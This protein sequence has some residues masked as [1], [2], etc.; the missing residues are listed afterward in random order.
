MNSD[1][2]NT[3]MRPL[4]L[5]ILLCYA[6][7]SLGAAESPMWK[8]LTP[9]QQ[10]LLSTGKP[11]VIEEN[12]GENPWPRYVVYRLVNSSAEKAAAVFW[13]CELDTR[14]IPNCLIVRTVARPQPWI[15][16]AEYT[17]KMPMF[18]PNEVYLSRN[19]L[20]TPSSGDYEISW[21]VLHARY[22][23]GSTGNIR[24]EPL[25]LTNQNVGNGEKALM[26]YSNLVIPGGRIACLLRAQARQQVVDS[27]NA[28]ARQVDQE[29]S[30][31]S[32][33]QI[34]ELKKALVGTD[35]AH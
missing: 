25:E 16:E 6:L 32:E 29:S 5:S 1:D 20:T 28:L 34:A 30:Q 13:D 27:V 22:I 23:T 18:L 7:A 4:F 8:S 12:V 26:R 17:L 11:V 3:G 19:E 31:V 10:E 9:Q 35:T 24:I 21:K 15:H 14:Y 2:K 33:K